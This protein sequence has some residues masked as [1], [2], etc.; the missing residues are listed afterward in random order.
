MKS[1]KMYGAC[2]Y[3]IRKNALKPNRTKK[4]ESQPFYKARKVVNMA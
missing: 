1:S 3:R 2:M 4:R